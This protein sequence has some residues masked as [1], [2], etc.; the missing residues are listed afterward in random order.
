MLTRFRRY[1]SLVVAG[2]LTGGEDEIADALPLDDDEG[3]ISAPRAEA[4]GDEESGAPLDELEPPPVGRRTRK[5]R[6]AA[7]EEGEGDDEE[8][9]DWKR[10]LL[11]LT[12]GEG[13]G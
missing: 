2:D 7:A 12:D 9:P 8:I 11:E 13:E 4:Y 5:S 6:A 1:A 3:P 10:K